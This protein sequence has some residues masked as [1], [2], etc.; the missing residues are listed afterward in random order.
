MEDNVR[1]HGAQ[2]KEIAFSRIIKAGKRIYY[3][4][5]K[6][7]KKDEMYLSI[8]ESKKILSGVGDSVQ[9]SFE[10]H[11]IFVYKEDFDKMREAINEAIDFIEERQGRAEPREER[12]EAEGESSDIKLDLDF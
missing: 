5:V 3:V 12:D 9:F 6:L 1:Q 8:T 10:K 2:A 4:D 7:N 11:K